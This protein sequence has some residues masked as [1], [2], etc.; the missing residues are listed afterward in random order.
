MFKKINRFGIYHLIPTL[1]RSKPDVIISTFPIAAGM[2]SLIKEAGW[3]RS[4]P[5]ITVITDHSVHS[6]WIHPQTDL[7]LV[8][9][10]A[11]KM[12]LLEM[13]V[14][15]DKVKVTGIPIHPK[16]SIEQNRSRLRNKYH[17]GQDQKVLL[18][19][20]GGVGIFKHFQPVLKQ[21][22][23]MPWK[24]KIVIICG[25]N[26]KLY[27]HF[28][29]ISRSSKHDIQVEAF[30]NNINEWMAIA[31]VMITKPGGLTISE[32]I[33]S[34]LPMIIFKPLGG[35]E[36]DNT[37]FL[38]SSGIAIAADNRSELIDQLNHLLAN[39]SILDL[40]RA[41]MQM[42]TMRR[43]E[44]LRPGCGRCCAASVSVLS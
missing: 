32:A 43:T 21:L 31:D 9:S 19:M 4:V 14:E 44:A 26:Q 8:G 2:M 30:V 37:H 23:N 13:G 7:Y 6:A 33:A 28:M 34:E 17:I 10:D 40:M 39:E 27:H 15:S 29:E 11:V 42:Q 22:D 20:G 16:F 24:L 36:A 5:L 35:Q 41:N 3:L 12:G 38:L 18:I 1:L 25:H